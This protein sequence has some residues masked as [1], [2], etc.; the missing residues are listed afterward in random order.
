MK[1]GLHL[2]SIGNN[3]SEFRSD[4]SE[5]T[6]GGM[7]S[8][9]TELNP[10]AE[11]MEVEAIASCQPSA[12]ILGAW[13]NAIPNRSPSPHVIHKPFDLC[14]GAPPPMV[15][16]TNPT[17][18]SLLSLD[19][20]STLSP[21]NPSPARKLQE[22][23]QQAGD[24]LDSEE[25]LSSIVRSL[26]AEM[27]SS[28]VLVDCSE[29]KSQ[30]SRLKDHHDISGNQS[31][32]PDACGKSQTLNINFKVP[33]GSKLGKGKSEANAIAL[34]A[35]ESSSSLSAVEKSN[36]TTSVLAEIH[37]LDE[38]Q[39]CTTSTSLS[40]PVPEIVAQ[41]SVIERI[42]VKDPVAIQG[43]VDAPARPYP[44]SKPCDELSDSEDELLGVLESVVSS[45][46]ESEDFTST[47]A[48]T[49][50]VIRIV[51]CKESSAAVLLM[52]Y[53]PDGF[54]APVLCPAP[55]VLV[56]AGLFML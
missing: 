39:P 7:M 5:A 47:V 45:K 6:T 15:S 10:P 51:F 29:L 52:F 8:V 25:R 28:G 18:P 12:P 31:P 42:V 26:E 48:A 43:Q 34:V 2:N 49:P 17:P 53:P 30:L 37:N 33:S 9:W 44:S 22:V 56:I 50:L 21:Q 32:S 54:A 14:P 27:R 13:D 41:D 46:K 11:A 40:I 55:V 23:F 36:D 24:R 4:L 20:C 19:S 1:S 16:S 35:G 38:L 3:W